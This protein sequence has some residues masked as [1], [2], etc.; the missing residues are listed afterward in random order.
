MRKRA[1]GAD[2]SNR[3]SFNST[4][5]LYDT[6]TNTIYFRELDT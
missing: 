6:D 2:I 5:G 3:V 4:F 1:A